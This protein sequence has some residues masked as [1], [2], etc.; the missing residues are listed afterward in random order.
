V[1]GEQDKLDREFSAVA[2]SAQAAG[3]NVYMIDASDRDR[4][5]ASADYTPGT[6]S[7]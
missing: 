5:V 2:A 1:W 3:A 6:A 4:E 7:M